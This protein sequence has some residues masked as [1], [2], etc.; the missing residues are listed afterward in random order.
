MRTAPTRLSF[1]DLQDPV[2][3]GGQLLGNV[4]AI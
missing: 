1:M 3:R 2:F 4:T